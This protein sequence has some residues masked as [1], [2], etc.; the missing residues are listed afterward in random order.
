MNPNYY[1]LFVGLGA[2]LLGMIVLICYCCYASKR[3]SEEQAKKDHKEPHDII[4]DESKIEDSD[5]SIK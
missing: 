3:S 1:I 2:F 5:R 4:P